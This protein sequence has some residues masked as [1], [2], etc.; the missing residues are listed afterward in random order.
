MFSII[1]RLV[2]SSD[3]AGEPLIVGIFFFLALLWDVDLFDS[4]F[5]AEDLTLTFYIVGFELG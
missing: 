5:T 3:V 4:S 1:G 2:P